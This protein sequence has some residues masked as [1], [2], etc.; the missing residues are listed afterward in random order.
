M[1]TK[2]RGTRRRRSAPEPN[3][4]RELL[5]RYFPA[6]ILLAIV[7]VMLLPDILVFGVC[8]GRLGWLR[9]FAAVLGVVFRFLL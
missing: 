3:P 5:A 6:W 1:T 8:F 2:T 7:L 4:G 9:G